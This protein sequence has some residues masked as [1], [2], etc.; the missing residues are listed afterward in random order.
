MSPFQVRTVSF[1]V[2]GTFT[3]NKKWIFQPIVFYM[4]F[5]ERGQEKRGLGGGFKYF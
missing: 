5:A 4:L 2:S 3:K 1:R